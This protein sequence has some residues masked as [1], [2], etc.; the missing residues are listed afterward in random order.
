ML[1]RIFGIIIIT[2]GILT[3]IYPTISS[4]YNEYVASKMI[5]LYTDN[6]VTVDDYNEKLDEATEYNSKLTK[7]TCLITAKNDL[8]NEQYEKLLNVSGN[9]IMG[10]L[11]IPKISQKLPIY[12]YSDEESL[13]AGIGHLHGSSL[14]VGGIGTNSV[15]TGHRGLPGNMIL[16]RMDEMDK[17]D[18]ISIRI[19]NETLCYEITDIRTVLPTETEGIEINP[20]KDL[21]TI[22]TCTPYGINSHRMVVT[23]ERVYIPEEDIQEVSEMEMIIQG[24]PLTRIYIVIAC[25][26]LVITIKVYKRTIKNEKEEKK[27]EDNP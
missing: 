10:Y 20:E 5:S 9:G 14:P 2:L 16:T 15:L 24:T 4:I 13:S 1:K 23:A 18:Q 8:K 17:G 25:V 27:D 11:Q 21:L 12:H 22:I 6:I 26:L 7:R 19:Y 3:F